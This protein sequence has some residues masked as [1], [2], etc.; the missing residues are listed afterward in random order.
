VGRLDGFSALNQYDAA[1]TDLRD[2]FT[3]T[4]DFT[5]YTFQNVQYAGGANADV[6]GAFPR[7]RF[8]PPGSG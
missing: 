6:A 2:M 4:P 8:Q 7:G 3:G 5:P 1:A